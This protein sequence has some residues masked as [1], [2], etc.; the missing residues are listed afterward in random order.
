VRLSEALD[1]FAGQTRALLFFI[2]RRRF[3]YR[4]VIER[5]LIRDEILALGDEAARAASS[6]G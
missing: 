4:L 5:R 3:F 1:Q 2:M 6:A